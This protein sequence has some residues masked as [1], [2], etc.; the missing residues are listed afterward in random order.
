[1]GASSSGLCVEIAGGA[2]VCVPNDVRLMTPY[3][4]QEQHDWF[5]DEIKFLRGTLRPG[6]Y[7][8]DCGA[9]YGV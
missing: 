7:V 1:M 9:N 5:E 8:V 3:V 4:L 6:Q 2:Q